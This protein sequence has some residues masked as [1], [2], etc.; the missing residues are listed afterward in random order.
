MQ[1]L[2]STKSLQSKGT[3]RDQNNYAVTDLLGDNDEVLTEDIQNEQINA[4][5]YSPYNNYKS[6]N[7][8]VN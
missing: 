3:E 8:V 2:R 7:K 5:P 4:M 1:L 6:P